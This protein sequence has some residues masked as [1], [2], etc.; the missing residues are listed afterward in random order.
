MSWEIVAGVEVHVELSTNTKIFCGCANAFGAEPNTLICPVC[1]GMPGA[2]P[3]LNRRVVEYALRAGLALDCD[4]ARRTTF[5]RKN[6][7]YP[8]LP[9]AYQ[10]SQLHLPIC[11]NG[12]LEIETPT[13]SKR[14]GIRQIHMEEDAGK[15]IHHPTRPCT[16][17]DYNRCG[18]PLLEIVS[19]PDFTAAHEVIAY[20]KSLREILLFLGV[21]DCKMQEGSLRV[22]L[23]VSVRHK[24]SGEQGIPTEMKNISSFQ[25]VGR[26]MVWEGA[27]QIQLLESGEEVLRET[28][29]WDDGKNQGF[30]LR[31]K[32]GAEDYRYLPDPD[33]PILEIT[34]EQVEQLRSTLPE[35]PRNKRARYQREMGLSPQDARTLTASREVAALFEKTTALC[36]NPQEAAN[37]IV[38]DLARLCTETA[39][40]PEDLQV[41]AAKLAALI[42]MIRSG[43]INRTVGKEVLEQIFFHDA[44]P[45]VYVA[46]KG[47]AMVDDP[48]LVEAAVRQVVEANPK[49]VSD[50]QN[51]KKKAF[52]YLVGQVMRSLKGKGDPA[53]VNGI[54]RELLEE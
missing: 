9:K 25:A 42:V 54:L 32:G 44:D 39:T 2:L 3:V 49:S 43:K 28:R 33:L 22:D 27:R 17:V 52:G 45:A 1:T 48:A 36:Q 14:I 30:V 38:G 6:Y 53:L 40:L 47:L 7:F 37:L 23:N 50:Y 15:L 34:Q 12:W 51:G 31:S 8:D 19:Q 29:R 18:V 21:S 5:D 24:G 13:G 11:Q 41:D 46:Q 4:I 16:L 26:A 35:L 10:I 20:L